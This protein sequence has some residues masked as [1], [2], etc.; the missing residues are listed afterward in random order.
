MGIMGLG[1]GVVR[2]IRVEVLAA[3]GA[4]MLRVEDVDVARV[5]GNQVPHVMQDAFACTVAE[6]GLAADGTTATPEVPAAVHDLGFG[7][8]LGTRDTFREV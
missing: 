5:T 8:I 1:Q 4:A 7:Q 6:T 3:A 2:H